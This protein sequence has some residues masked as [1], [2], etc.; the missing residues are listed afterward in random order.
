MIIYTF[1]LDQLFTAFSL[2]FFAVVVWRC[3]F[4]MKLCVYRVR[5]SVNNAYL[6]VANIGT[7]LSHTL[8]QRAVG[9]ELKCI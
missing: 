6:S 3:E 1:F 5:R 2:Y 9:S 7:G 8:A 4:L